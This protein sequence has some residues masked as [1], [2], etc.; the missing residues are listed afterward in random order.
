MTAFKLHNKITPNNIVLFVV[1]VPT[2]PFLNKVFPGGP[3]HH[4][5]EVL[6]KKNLTL[7]QEEAPQRHPLQ[8]L[9]DTRVGESK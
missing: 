5:D 3:S 9:R 7:P 6:L 2:E 1:E 8:L 4:L